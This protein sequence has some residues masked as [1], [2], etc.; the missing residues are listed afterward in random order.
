M[1]KHLFLFY[2]IN[3]WFN[4]STGQNLIS[5]GSF[6]KLVHV[7]IALKLNGLQ[8]LIKSIFQTIHY[9]SIRKG[10]KALY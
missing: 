6:S 1:R 2:Y 9:F 10:I 3:N 4:D 7:E 5:S 8:Q